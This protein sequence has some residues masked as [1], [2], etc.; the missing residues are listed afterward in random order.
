MI[1]FLLFGFFGIL[2]GVFA[3]SPSLYVR[4]SALTIDQI[5]KALEGGVISH[6]DIFITVR[7]LD[8]RGLV[9]NGLVEHFGQ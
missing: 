8:C 2:A 9:T 4:D 5:I 7:A 1:S 6:I 3:P